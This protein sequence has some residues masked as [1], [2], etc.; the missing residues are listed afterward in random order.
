MAR[1]NTAKMAATSSGGRGRGG[2]G[3]EGGREGGEGRQ[4][5]HRS[6]EWEGNVRE[7]CMSYS[8]IEVNG[9]YKLPRVLNSDSVAQTWLRDKSRQW[10]QR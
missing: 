3:R 1:K 9:P 8:V 2:G 10:V 5:C 6:A 7:M 4:K